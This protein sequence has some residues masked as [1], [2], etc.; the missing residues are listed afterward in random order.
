MAKKIMQTFLTIF[1]ILLLFLA[2]LL[3]A[4]ALTGRDPRSYAVLSPQEQVQVGG[5]TM[6]VAEL[7]ER[8]QPQMYLRPTTPSPALLWIWYEAVP[9]EQTIDLLYYFTWEN[10]NN[11]VKWVDVLYKTF[12]A[13]FYGYPLYDVEYIQVS[14]GRADASVSKLRFETGPGQDYYPTVSEHIIAEYRREAD[15]QYTAQFSTRE[16]E[17]VPGASTAMPTF[18]DDH[19]QLGVHTWNHLSRLI[20]AEDRDFSILQAAELKPL[21]AEEFARY[22]FVRKSQ[23]DHQVEENPLWMP[24]TSLTI[25]IFVSL[26]L[27]VA[28]RLTRRAASGKG[29]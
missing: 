20:T 9:S 21:S 27:A 17:A 15:G 13:A 12:R 11:P 14:V 18:K 19:V 16:G 29:G 10:E 2:V 3:L 28:R 1:G 24:I 26:P 25:L 6:R 22:K 5:E 7:A 4:A 23:G 8:Y